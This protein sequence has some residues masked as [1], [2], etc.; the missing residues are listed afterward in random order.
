[1]LVRFTAKTMPQYAGID[2]N[3]GSVKMQP[4]E[5]AEVSETVAKLLL[6]KY[7]A[8][9]EIVIEEKPAHAPHSDKL[10]RK[11]SKTKTK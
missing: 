5:T 7:G 9:F 2:G 4:N 1:M 11:S 10:Y 3:G 8:N 6:Q